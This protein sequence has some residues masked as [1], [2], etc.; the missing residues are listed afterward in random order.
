MADIAT[1]QTLPIHILN[2]VIR[3]SITVIAAIVKNSFFLFTSNSEE[4][5]DAGEE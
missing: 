1:I 3:L 5:Y 4:D 2:S